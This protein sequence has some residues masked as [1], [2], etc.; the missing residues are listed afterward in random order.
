M[1]KVLVTA[2]CFWVIAPGLAWSLSC[3]R[4]ELSKA[5]LDQPSAQKVLG[6]IKTLNV[7]KAEFDGWLLGASRKEAAPSLITVEERSIGPWAPAALELN[8]DLI[9]LVQLK[10]GEAYLELHPCNTTVFPATS[11]NMVL[12][13]VEPEKSARFKVVSGPKEEKPE[14]T[15]PR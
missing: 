12:L 2:S 4:P 7:G 14:E 8:K 3:A 6:Q 9:L 10:E 5:M 11:N 15:M 13:G 1:K